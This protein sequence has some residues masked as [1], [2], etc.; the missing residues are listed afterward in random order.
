MLASSR[1]LAKVGVISLIVL[2]VALAFTLWAPRSQRDPASKPSND[3]QPI[4]APMTDIATGSLDA[5]KVDPESIVV[6][7]SRRRVPVATFITEPINA[8][9]PRVDPS[10]VR[11][12]AVYIAFGAAFILGLT[13]V[14]IRRTTLNAQGKMAVSL[15]LAAFASLLTGSLHY[16]NAQT[17]A[18]I[19]VWELDGAFPSKGFPRLEGPNPFDSDGNVFFGWLRDRH[20]DPHAIGRLNVSTNTVTRWTPP[21]FAGQPRPHSVTVGP[22]NQVFFFDT[23]QGAI[24][25]LDPATSI[26]TVW[27]LS[28][29][30]FCCRRG[31]GSSLRIAVDAFSNVYFTNGQTDVIARL[32]TSTDTVTEWSLPVGFPYWPEVDSNGNVWFADV[33]GNSIGM[34]DPETDVITLWQTQGLRG[35]N[36]LVAEQGSDRVWFSMTGGTGWVDTITNEMLIV[37]DPEGGSVQ[38][39]DL[40]AE[41]NFWVI[42]N[43]HLASRDSVVRVNG[44][45]FLTFPDADSSR[46]LEHVAIDT[47][48]NVNHIYASRRFVQFG[49]TIGHGD[50]VRIT[51]P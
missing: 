39:G 9:V 30:D 5:V 22:E 20:S 36:G 45:N 1:I 13:V 23:A 3:N 43:Y 34:V 15:V 17:T 40:D 27:D 46:V 6:E 38:D 50:L 11:Y 48:V 42:R 10:K 12:L 8:V 7:P 25:S 14:V 18:N 19:T 2:L 37:I 35:P 16:A 51:L 31:T 26:F 32:D 33:I 47:K 21:A 41:R 44:G 24:G 4:A 29:S 28:L 49:T